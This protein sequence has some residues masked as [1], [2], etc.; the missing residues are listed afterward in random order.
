MLSE[1]TASQFTEWQQFDQ[2]EPIGGKRLDWNFG[3]V[4]ATIMNA[5]MMFVR[6]RKRFY[7]KDFALEFG[8]PTPKKDAP[9]TT[10]KDMKSTAMMAAAMFNALN[11]PKKRKRRNGQG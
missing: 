11:E 8:T 1:L 2:I 9:R 5:L 10:W 6:S 7:P 4:C 3:S